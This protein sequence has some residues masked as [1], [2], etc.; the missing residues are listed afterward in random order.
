MLFFAA[1]LRGLAMVQ[2]KF[3]DQLADGSFVLPHAFGRTATFIAVVF[4]AGA[5][6]MFF[7]MRSPMG[8][9]W[10]WSF[11]IG[12]CLVYLA[13]VVALQAVRRLPLLQ[14]SK[15]GIAI[16]GPLG[17][18]FVYWPDTVK[19]AEG[20]NPLWLR[21]HLREG[22]PPVGSAVT[23]MLNSSLWAS[24]TIAVPLFTTDEDTAEIVRALTLLRSRNLAPTIQ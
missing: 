9:W 21:I 10:A 17:R 22:A 3:D 13:L 6:V 1:S 2:S 20:T 19:F 11:L 15:S 18:M 12:A 16:N 24:R 7:G 5:F 14:A 4:A 23:R 8:F